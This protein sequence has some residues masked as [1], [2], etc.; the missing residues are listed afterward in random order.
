M[1]IDRGERNKELEQK[2][3]QK[4]RERDER[5]AKGIPHPLIV[6]LIHD[7]EIRQSQVGK[8]PPVEEQAV[9]ERTVEHGVEIILGK[10]R[11]VGEIVHLIRPRQSK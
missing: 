8:R 7:W 5:K 4:A 2:F 6:R 10:L 1:E 11:R 3:E 9:G